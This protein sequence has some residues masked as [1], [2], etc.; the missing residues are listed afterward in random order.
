MFYNK[1]GFCG[2]ELVT[3]PTPKLEDHP[4]LAVHGTFNIFTATLHAGGRSSICNLRMC[5]AVVTGTHLSWTNISLL[6][7][8]VHENIILGIWVKIKN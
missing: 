5:H 2:E 4:F 6:S 7:L 3:H 1:I 8:S